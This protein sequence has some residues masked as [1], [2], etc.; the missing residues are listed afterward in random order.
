MERL[1]PG[2]I[3]CRYRDIT[4]LVTSGSRGWKE[5][6]ATSGVI[7]IRAQNI[8]TDVL[9]LCDPAFVSL[10]DRVEGSR[11]QVR[12]WDIL[13]TITGSNVTKTALVTEP[14]AEAYVSQHIALT[15]PTWPDMAQWLHLCFLSPASARGTLETLAYGAKPGLNL[16]NI[17]ELVIPIPP[18]AEQ[19][20]IVAKVNELMAMC[21]ELEAKLTQSSVVSEK[22]AEAVVGRMGKNED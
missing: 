12:Q 2:W 22:L 16:S 7:F 9:D 18:L 13:I 6:Y 15:R 8:K 3:S 10:P 17:R 19:K 20:R 4:S 21:D 11:A 5:H 1:P 14:I